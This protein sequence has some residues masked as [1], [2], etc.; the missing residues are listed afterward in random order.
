M[1]V[2]TYILR[3]ILLINLLFFSFNLLGQNIKYKKINSLLTEA[4]NELLNAG[5]YE[6]ALEMCQKAIILSQENRYK[7]GVIRGTRYLAGYY[8]K[9]GE[10]EESLKILLSIV[11]EDSLIMSSSEYIKYH[12]LIASN[13]NDIGLFDSAYHYINQFLPSNIELLD[14][15]LRVLS[16]KANTFARK[17][18]NHSAITAYEDILSILKETP[19]LHHQIITLINLTSTK[20]RLLEI[21]AALEYA[22]SAVELSENINN[23]HYIAS[24]YKNMGYVHSYA[25]DYYLAIKF[26]KKVLPI[27]KELK[28][29]LE[30]AYLYDHI[31]QCYAHQNKLDSALGYF[32]MALSLFQAIQNSFGV[33]F[34]KQHI[35]T[36]L[37]KSKEIKNDTINPIDWVERS[38]KVFYENQYNSGV[39][40]AHKLLAE[41]YFEKGDTLKALE[42]TKKMGD[43]AYKID[44]FLMLVDSYKKRAVLERH[45]GNYELSN[46]WLS[47]WAMYKDSLNFFKRQQAYIDAT[48]EFEAKYKNKELL[49]ENTW[50]KRGTLIFIIVSVIIALLAASANKQR[51][52]AKQAARIANQQREIADN[53]RKEKNHSIKND[54]AFLNALLEQQMLEAGNNEMKLK[55]EQSKQA[56]NTVAELVKLDTA[57]NINIKSFLETRIQNLFLH[58]HRN[59]DYEIDIENISVD[60]STTKRLALIVNEL[61]TNAFKHAFNEQEKPF[62]KVSLK[63]IGQEYM[64][65]VYD[66]GIGFPEGC[67]LNT[68]TFRYIQIFVHQLEGKLAFQNN[69]GAIFKVL[70]PKKNIA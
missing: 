12:C 6:K 16:I 36:I 15:K 32:N 38:L 34:T 58:K 48:K 19:S 22:T 9:I 53:L 49:L 7:E 17:G 61:V 70:F 68:E 40:Q 27:Y 69:N 37:L 4:N 59:I 29:P 26:Y 51:K 23:K 57:E 67:S 28:M 42:Y 64:L 63:E 35:G 11:N 1:R 20:A 25:K 45:A 14:D 39:I 54:L 41:Y 13:Y 2:S 66:N 21:D 24:S 65:S 52:K 50:W 10:I 8:S 55:I 18:E 46:E 47:M 62:L 43:L 44:N 60:I 3:I 31:G 30:I 33:E 56:F 5:N